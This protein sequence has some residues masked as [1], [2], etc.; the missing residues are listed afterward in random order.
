LRPPYFKVCIPFDLQAG[1]RNQRVS[2]RQKQ[3][4]DGKESAIKRLEAARKRKEKVSVS[5]YSD[6]FIS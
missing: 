5:T 2:S 1:P 3:V 4:E 6:G